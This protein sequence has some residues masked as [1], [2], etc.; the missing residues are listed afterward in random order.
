[1]FDLSF[2]GA[3]RLGLAIV[4]FAIVD[5]VK[6]LDDA[7][8]F[9]NKRKTNSEKSRYNQ[10]VYY[11][12]RQFEFFKDYHLISIYLLSPEDR[13]IGLF[14]KLKDGLIKKYGAKELKKIIC[15]WDD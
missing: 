14:A 4:N 5:L 7:I 6:N 3:E 2:E 10:A 8:N 9:K 1:M 15:T 11:A 13:A 12:N